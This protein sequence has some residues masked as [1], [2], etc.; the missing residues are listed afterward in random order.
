MFDPIKEPID[1]ILLQG[2]VS[3]GIAIVSGAADK[4]KWDIQQGAYMTGGI[5]IYHG[6]EIS[7]FTVTIKLITEQDWIDWDNWKDLVAR[8]P[9]PGTPATPGQPNPPSP[10]V[11]LDIW[12]PFLVL[13]GISAVQIEEVG[14]FTPCDDTG[15]YQIEIK[16]LEFRKPVFSYAKP[17]SSTPTPD[18]DP[19]NQAIRDRVA[20]LNALANHKPGG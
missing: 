1:T 2:R 17:T 11:A 7:K 13:L 12:H 14:Q 9:L 19:N 15:G 3:P 8:P 20:Q 4:R 5:T 16:F 6:R 18:N 10:Y